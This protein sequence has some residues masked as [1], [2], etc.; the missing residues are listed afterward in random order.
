[1][2]HEPNLRAETFKSSS[3]LFGERTP[4]GKNWGYFEIHRPGGTL[5][6]LSSGTPDPGA[7]AMSD[8]EH[9]SVSLINR[10][11][12]W[13]EMCFVKDLF[14]REDEIVVQSHPKKSEYINKMPYCLH[15]WKPV[16]G[17]YVLPPK[18]TL[19]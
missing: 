3:L 12:T 5:R 2:R 9:V 10:C 19:A 15:L 16:V 4:A 6:V 17:E 11:P 1:M 14:W 18:E 8:W 13:E 7:G